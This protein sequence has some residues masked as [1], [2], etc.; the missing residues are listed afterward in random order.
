MTSHTPP[1]S[2]AM[3]DRIDPLIAERAPWLAAPRLS[4]RLARGALDQVLRYRETYGYTD[5]VTPDRIDQL[6][7]AGALSPVALPTQAATGS[8]EVLNDSTRKE[9]ARW[10]PSLIRGD[11][12]TRT[13]LYRVVCD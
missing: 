12:W 10:G 5:Y 4:S 11:T 7:S 13:A 6:V 3:Q 9:I 8:V 1:A 2:C